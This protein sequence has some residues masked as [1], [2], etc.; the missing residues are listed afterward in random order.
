MDNRWLLLGYGLLFTG[1]TI[2]ALY[3]G[4]IPIAAIAVS[5]AVFGLGGFWWNTTHDN[6]IEAGNA[7]EGALF[8]AK[9]VL[10]LVGAMVVSGLVS[11]ILPFSDSP[12]TLGRA[13]Q[14]SVFYTTWALLTFKLV[15][16]EYIPR[17]AFKNSGV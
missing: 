16:D 6:P 10:A 2:G 7:R 5:Q 9:V 15:F 1:V 3:Q 12:R 17:K 14:V 11:I 13:I 4:E 8:M